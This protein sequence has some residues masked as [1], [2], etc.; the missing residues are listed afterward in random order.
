MV[1]IDRGGGY[2]SRLGS[3]S[4]VELIHKSI[5]EFIISDIAH[6]ILEATIVMFGTIT[7][8]IM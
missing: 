8:G 3:G 7:E 6:D 4:G 2:G 5:R 1:M